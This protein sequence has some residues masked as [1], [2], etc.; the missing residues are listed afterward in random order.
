MKNMRY[1]IILAYKHDFIH[2]SAFWANFDT[3]QSTWCRPCKNEKLAIWNFEK[4]SFVHFQMWMFFAHECQFSKN[5][6]L[7]SFMYKLSKNLKLLL[8]L[9]PEIPQQALKFRS[10]DKFGISGRVLKFGCV[11]QHFRK[12]IIWILESFILRQCRKLYYLY[13]YIEWLIF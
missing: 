11:R 9:F 8:C 3:R 10:N 12:N 7:D 13:M 6:N 5:W 4:S 1:I 2:L